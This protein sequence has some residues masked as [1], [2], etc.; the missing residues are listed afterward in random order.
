MLTAHI[1]FPY[2][3]IQTVLSEYENYKAPHYV[4][5][6]ISSFLSPNFILR[7]FFSEKNS[8]LQEAQKK[9]SYLIL[10]D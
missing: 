2:V 10:H 5:F 8:S 3:V 6:S 9:V 4:I 1:F 7:F